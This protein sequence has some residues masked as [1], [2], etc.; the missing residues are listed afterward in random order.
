MTHK[1]SLQALLSDFTTAANPPPLGQIWHQIVVL[2]MVQCQTFDHTLTKLLN[3]FVSC[4]QVILL[5][6]FCL[7][8]L[9][10]MSCHH[11]YLFH[12]ASK[13]F[14]PNVGHHKQSLGLFS[15]ISKLL[16]SDF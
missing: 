4:D 3:D 1:S 13:N 15:S 5:K 14:V 6:C 11:C 2:V 8:V 16:F 7:F 9:G 10:V 12:V